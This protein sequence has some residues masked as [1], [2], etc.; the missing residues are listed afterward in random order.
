[1]RTSLGDRIVLVYVNPFY[2]LVEAIRGPLMDLAGY[3]QSIAAVYLMA[4]VGLPATLVFFSR[5]RTRVPY[6]V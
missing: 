5:Y 2:H 3:P 6:W 1:M 4:L